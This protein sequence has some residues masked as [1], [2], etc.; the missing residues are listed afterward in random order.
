MSEV[1]VHVDKLSKREKQNSRNML[2]KFASI[3][4]IIYQDSINTGTVL[5]RYKNVPNSE[6]RTSKILSHWSMEYLTLVKT[7]LSLLLFSSN[8]LCLQWLFKKQCY[9]CLKA[10]SSIHLWFEE[11]RVNLKTSLLMICSGNEHDLWVFSYSEY[12]LMVF[13]SSF[14]ITFYLY[15]YC[16]YK[17]IHAY[18][19]PFFC[20]TDYA[21]Y[22]LLKLV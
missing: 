6:T 21:F 8:H 2:L 14:L 9:N 11:K 5:S 20:F 10:E 17:L 15:M 1:E 7:F 18:T 13:F 12:D 19:Q 4:N 16:F 3:L 22:F